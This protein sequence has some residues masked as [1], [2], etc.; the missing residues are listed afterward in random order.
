MT[1]KQRRMI[2]VGLGA[3]LLCTATA[4]V[5]T[6]FQQDIVYFFGPTEIKEKQ[7]QGQITPGRT[8]RLGGLVATDSVVRE[9]NTTRVTFD[10]T[11]EISTVEVVYSGILP[12]LFREGQGVVVEG[13]LDLETGI[14]D[15]EEVLAKHDEN[16]MPAEVMEAL[17]KSGRLYEKEGGKTSGYGEA[18]KP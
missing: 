11:D 17:K 4:L 13:V 8:L 3:A 18:K 10:V 9:S 5:L 15:A 14:F 7:E 16:Y 12:D 2:F 1:R 6:A